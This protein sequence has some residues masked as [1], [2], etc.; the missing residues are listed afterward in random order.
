MNSTNRKTQA[1]SQKNTNRRMYEHEKALQKK[2]N[3]GNKKT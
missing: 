3:Q 2:S 1:R